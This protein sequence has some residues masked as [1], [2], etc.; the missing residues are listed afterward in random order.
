MKMTQKFWRNE[1]FFSS[2]QMLNVNLFHLIK[3]IDYVIN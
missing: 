3:R 1:K 2:L